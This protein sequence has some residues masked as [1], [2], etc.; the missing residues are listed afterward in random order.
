MKKK[1]LTLLARIGL[2][3]K[4]N[5]DFM[6]ERMENRIESIGMEGKHAS[7]PEFEDHVNYI[8][9]RANELLVN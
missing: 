1:A 5:I 3:F 4:S 8:N 2:M 6:I 7:L 9:N